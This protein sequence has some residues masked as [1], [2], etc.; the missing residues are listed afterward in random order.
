MVGE[1]RLS[2]KKSLGSDVFLDLSTQEKSELFRLFPVTQVYWSLSQKPLQ[3]NLANRMRQQKAMD[4]LSVVAATYFNRNGTQEICAFWSDQAEKRIQISLDQ[5]FALLPEPKPKWCVFAFG[6]LGSRELNLSSDVDLIWVSENAED[7]SLNIPLR[8]FQSDLHTV[9]EWGFAHRIDF[10]LRPGG[11]MGSIISSFEQWWDYFSNFIEA[12]ERLAFIRFRPVWGEADLIKKIESRTTALTFRKYLDFSLIDEFKAL[13]QQIH[14]QNWMR[15]ENQV[16][17][18]KLGIGGIRD[19]ELFIHTLQVIY[20]GKEPAVRVK[21][22]TKA[23]HELQSLGALSAKDNEFLE[24]HYWR[25][26]HFENLT[27]ARQD[28]QTHLIPKDFPEELLSEKNRQELIENMKICDNL[29][30]TLFGQLKKNERSLPETLPEQKAWV[31]GLGVSHGVIDKYWDDIFSQEIFS[32][33]K[34]R[35]DQAKKSFVYRIVS[36]GHELGSNLEILIPRLRDFIRKSRAKA[37]LF[38]LLLR[39]PE[40]LDRVIHLLVSSSYLSHILI[41]RPEILDI[42]LLERQPMHDPGRSWEE[43]VQVWKDRKFFSE[44]LNGL[45]FLKDPQLEPLLSSLSATADSI[46]QEIL[47]Q[48]KLEIPSQVEILALGKWGGQEIGLSSDLDFIFVTPADPVDADFQVARRFMNRLAQG[49][50]IYAIDLRL[51]PFGSSGTMMTSLPELERFI[52][53]EAPAWQRQCYLKARWL[54]PRLDSKNIFNWVSTRG[55]EKQDLK[56]LR[57]IQTEL[58]KKAKTSIIK[59]SPGG[60]LDLELFV[61]SMLLENHVV[62]LSSKISDHF[63]HFAKT[64][65]AKIH[66]NYLRLRQLEQ[67]QRLNTDQLFEDS[68]VSRRIKSDVFQLEI[69]KIL[70]ENGNYLMQLDPRLREG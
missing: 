21:S 66:E 18:L 67:L 23:M 50:P 57:G 65:P 55:L 47:Q 36:R 17:D 20:G 8:S 40:Q 68:E 58:H 37:T 10:D 14:S 35:D 28:E 38:H 29:V 62:P 33:Q 30:S 16:I 15:S 25:L 44:I 24:S 39:N 63:L 51:K 52:K 34:S 12:W 2:S 43:Q 48:I 45:N 3:S 31:A 27:Q 5:S 22:T 32:R 7:S 59:F 69:S 53:T 61:Q 64:W 19:L 54:N 70:S 56:E 46:A 13:R 4:F 1:S 11:R 26:R 41:N 49:D 42:V 6:K 60:L 9:S